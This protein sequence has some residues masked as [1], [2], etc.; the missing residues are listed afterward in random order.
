MS[1]P[2]RRLAAQRRS[3]PT[4]SPET[5]EPVFVLVGILR[6][7]H[8]LRGE[9]L[10]SVETDFPERLKKGLKLFL[11][12]DHTPLTI[13]NSR[14]TSDGL[15]LAF[16][17]FSDRESLT[18][19]RNEPLFVR[20]VDSPK[21]PAGQVYQHQLIGLDVFTQE[22]SLLGRLVQVM[23]TAANDVYVVHSPQEE[24][25]LLP[26]IRDVICK[27]DLENKRIIVHLLPGLLADE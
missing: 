12:E 20:A 24:E 19:V 27:V 10:V 21:L 14:A 17:E 16:E 6:R 23:D 13:R 5:S 11:G 25:I 22:G 7:P 18:H 2:R 3:Q 15:L 8:G 4:G 9:A 26:A 1:S